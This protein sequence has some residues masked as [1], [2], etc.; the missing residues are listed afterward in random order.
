MWHFFP[1]L[2]KYVSEQTGKTAGAHLIEDPS[3][4]GER[5]LGGPPSGN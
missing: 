4:R 3:K 1:N 5:Q 2:D